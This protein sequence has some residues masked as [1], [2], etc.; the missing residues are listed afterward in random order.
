VAE[1]GVGV[2]VVVVSVVVVPVVVVVLVVELVVDVVVV[3]LVVVPVVVVPV[4]LVGVRQGFLDGFA[5]HV[6]AE[7]ATAVAAKTPAITSS[8]DFKT[9]KYDQCTWQTSASAARLWNPR[10]RGP[11][12]APSG[13]QD[14]RRRSPVG[15]RT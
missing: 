11:L 10:P 1:L 9:C 4:V 5:G 6:G 15:S 12:Q 3:P 14:H 13:Y 2:V 8:S 7:R